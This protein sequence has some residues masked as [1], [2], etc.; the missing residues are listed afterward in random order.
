MYH[1]L[2][3]PELA[4]KQPLAP[5]LKASCKSRLVDTGRF[6][7][8]NSTKY[9][10]D[11]THWHDVFRR[12][13]I[14]GA[15]LVLMELNYRFMYD[16]QCDLTNKGVEARMLD[17]AKESEGRLT[18]YKTTLM[19]DVLDYPA[20]KALSAAAAVDVSTTYPRLWALYTDGGKCYGNVDRL[21]VVA[22][23]YV[24]IAKFEEMDRDDSSLRKA[25]GL[26]LLKDGEDA[27]LWQLRGSA[28]EVMGNESN[29]TLRNTEL[30][31][32]LVKSPSWNQ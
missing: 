2:I 10:K 22:P 6:L 16:P 21:Y 31:L 9:V 18:A 3:N 27:G 26:E 19:G 15:A 14:M 28:E 25:W 7:D 17:L 23:V 4:L 29:W 1:A 20:T 30:G 8:Y 5:S 11:I 32:G 12:T 24:S 13:E